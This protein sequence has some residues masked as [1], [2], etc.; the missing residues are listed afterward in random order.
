MHIDR[1]ITA[2]WC[3]P[4]A[5]LVARQQREKVTHYLRSLTRPLTARLLKG[6][7]LDGTIPSAVSGTGATSSASLISNRAFF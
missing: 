3:I 7:V 2:W 1:D 6:G 5:Q 4:R